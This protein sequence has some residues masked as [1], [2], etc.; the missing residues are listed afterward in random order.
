MSFPMSKEEALALIYV[1][2]NASGKSPSE[3]VEIYD[4]ALEQINAKVNEIDEEYRKEH[5]FIPLAN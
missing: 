5:E 4:R 1:Q 2:Q 3:L